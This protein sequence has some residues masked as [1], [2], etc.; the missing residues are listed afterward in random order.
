[1]NNKSSYDKYI[2]NI[3]NRR[4]KIPKNLPMEDEKRIIEKFLIFP[5]C[6]EGE[7]RWWRRAKI[8]QTAKT[9][10]HYKKDFWGTIY[11]ITYKWMDDSWKDD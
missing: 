11:K 5:K 6:I 1:M 3:V 4:I 2:D 10:S 8:C 7:Y 9:F